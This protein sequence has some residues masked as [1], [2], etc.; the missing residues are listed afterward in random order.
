MKIAAI[1]LTE[2]GGVVLRVG[3]PMTTGVF[4]WDI[5]WGADED[6]NAVI[7]SLDVDGLN[8]IIVRFERDAHK[9]PKRRDMI[10]CNE[11]FILI[12]ADPIADKRQPEPPPEL[13]EEEKTAEARR[14]LAAEAG[15]TGDV[16][17]EPVAAE[18]E[19]T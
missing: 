19:G 8:R 7:E 14:T 10:L 9:K 12:S 11:K 4:E 2:R 5:E 3:Q 13:S 6:L 1:N 17:L 15:E 16:D 18:V